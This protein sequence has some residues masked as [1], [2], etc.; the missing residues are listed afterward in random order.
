MRGYVRTL[1]NFFKIIDQNVIS[2][3]TYLKI[4]VFFQKIIYFFDIPFIFDKLGTSINLYFPNLH[5]LLVDIRT[6]YRSNRDFILYYIRLYLYLSIII[7]FFT[8]FT[9]SGILY[10]QLER[11]IPYGEILI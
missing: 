1:N 5:K 10:F 3:F 11:M 8:L 2:F 9:L 4:N 7:H 6:L